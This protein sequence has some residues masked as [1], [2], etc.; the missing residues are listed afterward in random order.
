MNKEKIIDELCKV[1]NINPIS[2]EDIEKG[3]EVLGVIEEIKPCRRYVGVHCIDGSCP[4]AMEEEY[5]DRCMDIITSCEECLFY[6]GCKD[7]G[8]WGT[9]VCILENERSINVGLD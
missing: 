5:A 9:S 6:Y 7:C 8:W 1:G 2:L 3:F 4:K